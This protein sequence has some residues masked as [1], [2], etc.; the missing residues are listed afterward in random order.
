MSDEQVRT[1]TWVGFCVLGAIVM[2]VGFFVTGLIE[3]LVGA[4]ACALIIPAISHIYNCSEGW[5]RVTLTLITISLGVLAFFT[6]ACAMGGAF[7]DGR[8]GIALSGV[9]ALLFKP[10]LYSSLATQFGV[11]FFTSARPQRGGDSGKRLWLIGRIGIGV[12]VCLLTG[13]SL[14]HI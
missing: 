7:I 11:G 14:I 5:P 12:A 2:I 10:F 6:T 3:M 9:A 8:V 4:L 13:L 1:S